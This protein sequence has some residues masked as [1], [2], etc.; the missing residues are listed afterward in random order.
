MKQLSDYKIRTEIV[1][2][3]KKIDHYIQ[4]ELNRFEPNLEIVSLFHEQRYTLRNLLLWI[5]DEKSQ[6]VIDENPT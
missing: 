5:C 1:R 3:A 6:E 2:R 4:L